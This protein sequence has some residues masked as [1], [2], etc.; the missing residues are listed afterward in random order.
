MQLLY[1]S[2]ICCQSAKSFFFWFLPNFWDKIGS[3]IREDL[4]LFRSKCPKVLNRTA[5][6]DFCGLGPPTKFW[7]RL[8][9][10][11]NHSLHN[12]TS[13]CKLGSNYLQYLFSPTFGKT[14]KNY[15]DTS[16]NIW[17][18]LPHYLL[19]LRSNSPYHLR[20]RTGISI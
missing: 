8:C 15:F 2:L 19:T 16:Q 6:F 17:Q 12:C 4:F 20:G 5:E 18:H 11:I 7:L 14:Q 1:L 9:P 3:S 10:T 13:Y